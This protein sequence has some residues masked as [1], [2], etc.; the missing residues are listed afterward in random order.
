MM[1]FQRNNSSTI[2]PA[3]TS[4]FPFKGVFGLKL[5]I[6]YRSSSK[7][8]IGTAFLDAWKKGFNS[9]AKGSKTRREHGK[10]AANIGQ[11]HEVK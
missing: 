2:R 8:E 10:F 11:K 4:S 6:S 9:G 5:V 1:H 7:E 3:A